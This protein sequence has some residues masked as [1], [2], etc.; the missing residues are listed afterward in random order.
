[1]IPSTPTMHGRPD[2]ARSAA[3]L[4]WLLL[5]AAV[6][7]ALPHPDAP[8]SSAAQAAAA[9][10]SAPTLY[11]QVRPDGAYA[12]DG[13][14][15]SRLAVEQALRDAHGQSPDLR[16]RIDADG[17]DPGRLIEA[18]ALADHAGI[19]NVGSLVL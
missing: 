18:L 7:L 10:T 14:Q 12:L 17:G 3:W 6:L 2:A 1:M 9:A 11:L 4:A 15:A 13:R 19:H 5:A 16:L 8:A